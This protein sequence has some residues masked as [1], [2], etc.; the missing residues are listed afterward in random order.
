MKIMTIMI[1]FNARNSDDS[2][3]AALRSVVQLDKNKWRKN[4]DRLDEEE[5]DED[6]DSDFF[7]SASIGTVQI[8][9]EDNLV[10]AKENM[11]HPIEHRIVPP[12]VPPLPA[13]TTRRVIPYL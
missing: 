11:L 6:D 8:L 4:M 5:E 13:S 9:H 7:N 1:T 2:L 3:N 10:G 12:V